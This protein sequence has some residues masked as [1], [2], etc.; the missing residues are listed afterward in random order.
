LPKPNSNLTE[1]LGLTDVRTGRKSRNQADIVYGDLELSFEPFPKTRHHIFEVRYKLDTD[2]AVKELSRSDDE[3]THCLWLAERVRAS[4]VI[5]SCDPA[6]NFHT[7]QR[8]TR[9]RGAGV[10]SES[11]FKLTRPRPG[12]VCSFRGSR[13]PVRVLFPNISTKLL[14]NTLPSG[15]DDP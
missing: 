4:N 5:V 15:L 12:I 9:K 8:I 10:L 13:G 11:S 2:R 7:G 1:S 3:M 6:N 14:T